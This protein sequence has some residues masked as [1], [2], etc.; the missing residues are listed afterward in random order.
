MVVFGDH[1]GCVVETVLIRSD[2]DPVAEVYHAAMYQLLGRLEAQALDL[3]DHCIHPEAGNQNFG[4]PVHPPH[5]RIMEVVEVMMGEIDPIGTQH[6]L[7]GLSAG[8]EMPP[9][10]L[11]F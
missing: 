6:A 8:R 7:I 3:I 4:R 10:P 9:R 2:P 5:R 1:E 11:F